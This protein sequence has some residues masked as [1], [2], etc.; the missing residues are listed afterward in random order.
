MRLIVLS[1]ESC[2]LGGFTS[3]PQE[4]G[5]SITKID[6]DEDFLRNLTFNSGVGL[7]WSALLE[8]TSKEDYLI[9]ALYRTAKKDSEIICQSK[10]TKE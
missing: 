9:R 3:E 10:K 5:F 4:D 7:Y 1:T 2:N 6:G 8:D